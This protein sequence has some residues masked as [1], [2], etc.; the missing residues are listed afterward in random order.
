MKRIKELLAITMIGEGLLAVIYPKRHLLLW[1]M[2][3]PGLRDIVMRLVKRPY[4]TRLLAIAEAGA[5][6]WLAKRQITA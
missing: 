6:F 4:L 3:I 1:Q 2:G 5:G